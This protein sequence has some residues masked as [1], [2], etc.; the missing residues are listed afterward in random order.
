MGIELKGE[1]GEEVKGEEVKVK[2]H[3]HIHSFSFLYYTIP[4]LTQI[5]IG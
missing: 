3:S 1:S 2:L 4:G 5:F